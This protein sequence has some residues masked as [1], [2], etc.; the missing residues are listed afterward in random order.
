[1]RSSE[2]AL[3]GV[4]PSKAWSTIPSSRSPRVMSW[5]SA[6]PFRTLRRRFSMRTPVW[7]RSTSSFESSI[8]GTSVPQYKDT[9]QNEGWPPEPMIG[10]DVYT[11]Q[12][13]GKD[14]GQIRGACHDH[15]CLHR[16]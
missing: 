6:K 7:T 10:R 4:L 12:K 13:S 9:S 14:Q 2:A 8:M 11:K 1:M 15:I 5:Y 16:G 3:N